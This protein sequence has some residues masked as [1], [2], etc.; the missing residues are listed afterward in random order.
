MT[1]LSER[2][3][4]TPLVNLFIPFIN[5]FDKYQIYYQRNVFSEEKIFLLMLLFCILDKV[6]YMLSILQYVYVVLIYVHI[7]NVI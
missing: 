6:V 1:I 3:F 2:L 5:N 7:H 4:L